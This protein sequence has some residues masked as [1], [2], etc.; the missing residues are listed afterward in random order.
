MELEEVWDLYE[1]GLVAEEVA[2]ECNGDSLIDNLIGFKDISGTLEE[3]IAN[4]EKGEQYAM[5]FLSRDIPDNY[6]YGH[7]VRIIRTSREIDEELESVKKESYDLQKPVYKKVWSGLKNL[8]GEEVSK[9]VHS[10]NL[11]EPDNKD[12]RVLEHIAKGLVHDNWEERIDSIRYE[13]RM[14]KEISEYNLTSSDKEYIIKVKSYIKNIFNGRMKRLVE[15][16]TY[17]RRKFYGV[18]IELEEFADYS[19]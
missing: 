11:N 18:M 16:S 4:V 9:Q 7:I 10:G 6:L 15:S 14:F 5:E 17:M 13:I 1:K 12:L 3:R 2:M 8:F 19:L